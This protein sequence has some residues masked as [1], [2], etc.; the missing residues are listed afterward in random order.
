M[1]VGIIIYS[2]TGNTLSV[3]EK[4]KQSLLNAGHTVSIERITAENEDPNARGAVKLTQIPN[5]SIYDHVILGAPVQGFSLSPIMKAY[6]SQLTNLNGRKI[7]C[8]VT[9]NFPKAWMGGRQAIKQMVRGISQKGG[10]V[11]H[12]AH[13]NWTNKAREQQITGVVSELGEIGA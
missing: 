8:Y 1:K 4:L 12:T 13:V 9:Q 6:L 7:A 3:A 10:S 2:R 5:I 11:M